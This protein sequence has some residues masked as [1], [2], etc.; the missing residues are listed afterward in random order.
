MAKNGKSNRIGKGTRTYEDGAPFDDVHYL[1]A[2]VPLKPDHLS[3]LERFHDFD[4][5]VRRTVAA[6]NVGV[7]DDRDAG[8]PPRVREVTFID[9]PEFSLYNNGFILR[10][11]IPYV[12][13]FPIGDPEVVFKYRYPDL[14]GAAALDVRPKIAG[15]YQI[16]FKIQALPQNEYIGGYRVL[17]SHSCQFGLSQVLEKDRT[18][19]STL[20]RVFPALSALKRSKDERV[21]LVNEGIVEELLLPLGRLDF[22]KGVVAK[23]NL[24]LWRTRG[25]HKPVIGEY[26]F[27][28]KFKQRTEVPARTEQRVKQFFVKLQHDLEDWI[29]LGTTKTGLVYRLNGAAGRHE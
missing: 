5:R 7:I 25:E 6:L 22:G 9:T 1:Q 8:R 20:T 3:S 26:S 19:L 29:S 17:Y 27:Q 4:K 13:G 18:A 10:R 12:D 24:A 16:K 15:K 21:R 11:R 2:K 23:S 28:L 14:R